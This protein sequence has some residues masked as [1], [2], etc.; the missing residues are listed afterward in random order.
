[1]GPWFV[2]GV[3]TRLLGLTAIGLG[4]FGVWGPLSV[5][6]TSGKACALSI[7]L[8]VDGV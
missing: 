1:M 5:L 6:R 2:P 3:E 4:L 8:T 7:R